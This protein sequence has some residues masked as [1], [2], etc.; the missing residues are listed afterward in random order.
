MSKHQ[1]LERFY[2]YTAFRPGQEALIDGVLSGRDVF[3]IMPTGGG[4][5][6]CYQVP[7]LMLPGITLVVSPLISLMRDQVMALKGMGIP[8]AYINSTL[9]GQQ[10]QLVYRNLLAGLYK[11]VYIAP[12]RLDYAGFSGVVSKLQV[13][14]VAVDEAHCIS[15][16]GQDFRPSYLRIVNFIASLPVRPVVGAFTATATP[17]VREDIER[18]LQLRDPVRAVTGFDR[19]NLFFDVLHPQRKEQELLKLL[20]TRRQK[21]GIVYCATRK[22][23]EEVCQTLRDKGYPATRYHAGLEE[24]E[25][26]QN[27]EDFIHDRAPIMVATNAFG[28]GIDKSNVS[29][30]I[31]YNMPKCMEAYYQEAGRAGRDGTDADCILLYSGADIQTA[32]FFINSDSENEELDEAQRERIRQQ[33]LKRLDAMVAYCKT[34]QCL[35]GY[36]LEY[37]GQDHPQACGN[38]G[39]CSAQFETRDITKEAQI[40]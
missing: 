19:P 26:T 2:G 11:I 6:I 38:C 36:I 12:E 23:V 37:F 40:Q 7:S 29:F 8:A 3:G 39:I 13:S 17:Q 32:K 20:A 31:H 35:R 34:G 27:Q 16:W 18:I 28:M 24:A 10:M 22:K 21:S 5:S 15:Q 1:I 9:S 25:R 33:D 30:V 4:K 14:F